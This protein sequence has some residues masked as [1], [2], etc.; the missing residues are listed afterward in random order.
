[1]A[2]RSF[3]LCG[4]ILC[5]AVSLLGGCVAFNECEAPQGERL[6]SAAIDL[7]LRETVVR[8]Q[9]A[10]IGNL[11]ADA[12][13][14][15]AETV[16][17]DGSIPC[18]DLALQNAGGLRQETACG[19]REQV[20]AGLVFERDVEDLMP[21]END[22][23]V[24]TMTGADVKLALERAVSSLGQVGDAAA[25]GYFLHVSGLE[26]GVDCEQSPQSLSGDQLSV[27]RVGDRVALDS[28]WL[29]SQ[30]RRELLQLDQE[31]EVATNSFIGSGGDGF[32][33]FYFRDE[34]G[35]VLLDGDDPVRRLDPTTDTARHGDGS[36]VKDRAA[37]MDYLRSY[38]QAGIPVGRPPEGRI[39]ID[40]TC[41]GQPR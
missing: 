25:A 7:D 17:L 33:S 40:S 26:F 18:P 1:M 24:V 6:G 8:T 34:D 19:T 2:T 3:R 4:W 31:Y 38:D 5:C 15:V 21:F 20:E 14:A 37:V 23:V 27:Q 16:C 12:L 32:L 35:R 28:I 11:V 29:T 22:L 10:S 41:Y 30:N 36:P 9:E 39:Q 13:Y